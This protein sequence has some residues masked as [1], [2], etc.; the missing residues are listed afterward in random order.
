[1]EQQ[2][3]AAPARPTLLTVLCILTWVGSGIAIVMLFLAK[4]ALSVVS[5][6][7]EAMG[8]LGAAMA[9][10]AG[11]SG[12]AASAEMSKAMSEVDKVA[13]NF[14]T[15]LIVGIICALLCIVGSVMMWKLKKTGFYVYVAGELGAPIAAIVLLGTG[16][17][18]EGGMMIASTFV[19]PILF[20]VLYGLNLKHM[21]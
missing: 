6:G 3:N 7:A 8:N 19:L 4:A 2:A 21:K 20:V 9:E 5:S 12:S 13:A 17:A 1:M 14:G 15:Y 10:S 16:Y 18:M 11:E